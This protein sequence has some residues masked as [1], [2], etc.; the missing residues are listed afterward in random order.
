[1][2]DI[3]RHDVSSL[4]GFEDSFMRKE[5]ARDESFKLFQFISLAIS[6]WAQCVLQ[7]MPSSI[8]NYT[9]ED[10]F[11]G[12]EPMKYGSMVYGWKMKEHQPIGIDY[13]SIRD[14]YIEDSMTQH[15]MEFDEI[16]KANKDFGITLFSRRVC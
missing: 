1:M 15:Y 11:H 13:Q 14:D 5:N 9:L 4:H 16:V 12:G 10:L 3:Q 7:G 8:S 2:R 6:T